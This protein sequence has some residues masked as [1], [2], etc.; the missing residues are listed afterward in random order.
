MKKYMIFIFILVTGTLQAQ[1][2]FGI[3]SG[4][5]ISANQENSMVKLLFGEYRPFH[6]NGFKN[7]VHFSFNSGLNCEFA[8]SKNYNLFTA[9][10]YTQKAIR[11]YQAN[12][13]YFIDLKYHFIQLPLILK[14]VKHNFWFYEIGL[15]NNFMLKRPEILQLN[16][17]GIQDGINHK[18]YNL[19]FHIG[20]GIKPFKNFEITLNG[21]Y[22]LTPY[23]SVTEIVGIYHYKFRFYNFNL[24]FRYYFYEKVKKE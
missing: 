5:G 4:F 1:Y 2:K 19:G 13:N 3:Y 22:D 9:T 10:A 12:N 8:I 16:N 6:S 7:T 18:F 24:G 20:T 15:V 21:E 23:L 17:A 14:K 11:Y